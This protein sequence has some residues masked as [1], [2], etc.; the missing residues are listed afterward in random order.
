[1]AASM[2]PRAPSVSTLLEA[3]LSRVE[4]AIDGDNRL[5]RVESVGLSEPEESSA[6]F[7]AEERE[8]AR[9]STSLGTSTLKKPLNRVDAANIHPSIRTPEPVPPR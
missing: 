8:Q 4:S 1:M 3:E 2:K 7:G 5:R 9:D 6:G